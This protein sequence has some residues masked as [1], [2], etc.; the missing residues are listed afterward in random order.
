MP[1]ATPAGRTTV[2]WL[3]WIA[4][5]RPIDAVEVPEPIE[6]PAALQGAGDTYVLRVRG[7]SMA[8]E[9]ILDGDWVIVERR[10]LARDGE[11]VVALVDGELATLKR[12]HRR[13][14]EVVLAP[15]NDAYPALAYAAERVRVQGVV[16][17]QMRSYR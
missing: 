14:G 3:G 16:V 11:V 5:G 15:A 9:G 12:L 17:G 10:E 4:A 13:G 1:L 6:I 2:P 7:D 8:D